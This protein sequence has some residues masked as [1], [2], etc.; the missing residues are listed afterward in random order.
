M[1][2]SGRVASEVSRVLSF[3]ERLS[4]RVR[5]GSKNKDVHEVPVKNEEERRYLDEKEDQNQHHGDYEGV[6]GFILKPQN[7][8]VEKLALIDAPDRS[9]DAS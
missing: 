9:K 5:E 1:R 6:V 2:L 3:V 4:Q 8:S 7:H